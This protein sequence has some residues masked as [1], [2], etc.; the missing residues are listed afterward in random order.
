MKYSPCTLQNKF[1]L[2]TFDND[3]KHDFKNILHVPEMKIDI[4]IL[5][6]TL[7]MKLMIKKFYLGF[8]HSSPSLLLLFS[9]PFLCI[10]DVFYFVLQSFTA[11]YYVINAIV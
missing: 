4:Y 1:L 3:L 5:T 7:S 10:F 9:F 6:I 2:F 8:L 11:I